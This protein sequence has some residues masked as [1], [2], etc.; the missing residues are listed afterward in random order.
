MTEFTPEM[1]RGG[2]ETSTEF[3]RRFHGLFE[4]IKGRDPSARRLFPQFYYPLVK[5]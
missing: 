4:R 2:R 1:S 5:F 3:P